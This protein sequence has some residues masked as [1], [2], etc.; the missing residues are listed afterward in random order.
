MA[1]GSFTFK[2]FVVRQ[3]R[4]AMKVGTDGVALGAWAPVAGVRRI[5]DIGTGSGLIALMLA[6]RTGAECQ[7]VAVELDGAAAEQ[8]AE[9]VAA[10]PWAE[11]ISV[12][13]GALQQLNSAPFDLVVSNPPYFPPGQQFDSPMRQQARHTSTLDHSEL[14][15]HALRLLAPNGRIALIL[16]VTQ[17]KALIGIAE[18]MDLFLLECQRLIPVPGKAANRF[19]LLFSRDKSS[20]ITNDL[21][22]STDGKRYSEIYGGMVREFYLKL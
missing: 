7:I 13:A 1:G 15:T 8:A 20:C 22:I 16:P 19:L 14:L 9:N 11:R 21:V 10:S 18:Q 12:V 4:C 17:A 3:D 5:L 6:Q 2:Q